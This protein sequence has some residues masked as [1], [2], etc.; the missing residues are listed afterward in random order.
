M[1][2]DHF[3]EL[4]MLMEVADRLQKKPKVAIRVNMDTGIYPMWDR[5]GFN[6][7]N[8]DAWDAINRIMMSGKFE[9]VGLHTHI[10]TYML[11]S[12]AFAIAASKL[13]DLA[14]RIERKYETS[15][16]YIDLGG[17]FASRNTLKGAYLPARIRFLHLTSM[18]KQLQGHFLILRLTR[19]GCLPLYWRPAGHLSTM[20]V[21]LSVLY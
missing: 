16:R 4:Y 5:F 15:L 7:E 11:S 10:G 9:M 20:P 21:T 8:G 1:H 6:Y 17:G 14:L 12:N 3:D 2:I 13:A 19:R 18:P